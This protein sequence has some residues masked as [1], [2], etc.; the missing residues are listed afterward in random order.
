MSAEW[1]E[2]T[3]AISGRL[4]GSLEGFLHALFQPARAASL[5]R[6]LIIFFAIWAAI[7]I[8]R[9]IWVLLPGQDTA[10]PA[11]ATIVNPASSEPG[12]Q[13]AADVDI[14]GMQAW[15]LFGE[16]G[17]EAVAEASAPAQTASVREGIE[18][19]ARETRLDLT[20][21]GVVASTEDGLG[22]AIIEHKS[23]Q[24]VYAVEDVLPVSGKV[25]LAKVMPQ[26]VVLDNAGTYE[27]LTLFDES[28]LSAQ[29]PAPAPKSAPRRP[30]STQ[31][32]RR[33]DPQTT[34]LA[35]SY[36]QQLYS[37]PQALVDV[38]SISAVRNDGELRGY[39]IGPGKDTAQF[40]QLGF[41]DGDVVT[42]VNGIALDDPANTMQLYQTMRT[43]SEA[44]FDL[45]RNNEP[46][47]VTVSLGASVGDQ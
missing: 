47:S 20:L 38:V 28:G 30:N 23:R 15:H 6:G 17:A 24:E 8:G 5:R 29:I 1:L 33:D 39:R 40:Q 13:A 44:V 31:R 36:R 22:H 25:T 34:S 7:A 19:N 2:K 4:S 26:Q 10:L 9:L 16:S 21:R 43:A 32:E 14:K 35:S 27:L 37:N 3:S 11:G 12:K 45:E 18:E 46:V 42:S 41:Q